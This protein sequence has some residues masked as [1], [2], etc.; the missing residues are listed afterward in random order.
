M[1]ARVL[2]IQRQKAMYFSKQNFEKYRN[3]KVNSNRSNS[4]T[5]LVESMFC[6]NERRKND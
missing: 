5:F 3:E 2:R 4:I 6:W 1:I